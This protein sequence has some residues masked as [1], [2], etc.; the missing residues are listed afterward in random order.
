MNRLI[1]SIFLVCFSEAVLALYD[2]QGEQG[3][4][5]VRALL[6]VYGQALDN[7]DNSVFF[8]ESSSTGLAELARLIAEG[9]INPH[10]GF[11]INLY[12]SHIP[13]SLVIADPSR[14]DIERSARLEWSFS[15]ADFSRVA[16]DRLNVRASWDR[17]DLTFGRQ[18]INLATTFYFSPNDFFAPFAAQ[19]FFRVYKSG[20]DAVRAE[21]RIGEL[22]QLSLINVLGYAPDVTTDTGWSRNADSQRDSSVAR[23]STV[24]YDKEWALLVGQVRDI[25]ILGAS[26]QGELFDWLGVRAEGHI[27]EPALADKYSELSIGIEHRWESSLD[28]RLE[29][30]HHGSGASRVADYLVVATTQSNYLARKY[31]ATGV[32]YE[33]TPL[34]TGNAL[35]IKNLLDQSWLVSLYAV[36]SLSD[37]AELA[38][39][40]SLSEGDEPVGAMI[41]SE[42]GTSPA[43]LNIEVRSYF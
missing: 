14:R 38:I 35:F 41:N 26:F 21:I 37:E 40:L 33:F 19:S 29:Y 2:W 10:L 12:Q 1:L 5:D 13:S 22:S 30:F 4:G 16:F 15:D 34:L 31:L 23:V 20:V 11:E 25:D 17:L 42:F 28:L 18:A 39:N 43:A 9:E 27:A 8:Q 6:R 24:L 7:P 36:Y 32:A 3:S